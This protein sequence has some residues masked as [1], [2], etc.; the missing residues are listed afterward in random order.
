M[1]GFVKIVSSSPRLFIIIFQFIIFVICSLIFKNFVPS[2]LNYPP[3]SIDVPFQLLVNPTYYSVYY[4]IICL[5]AIVLETL[6]ASSFLK[7][8]KKLS[9][10]ELL[11]EDEIIKIRKV[12]Y[13]FPNKMLLTSTVLPILIVIAVLLITATNLILSIKIA[14]LIVLFLGVPNVIIYIA[15]NNILRLVLINTF[16]EKIFLEE[17]ANKSKM[18][19]NILF[20]LIPVIIL[21]LFF[22]LMSFIS[23]ATREFGDY[24]SQLYLNKMENYINNM[25]LTEKIFDNGDDVYNYIIKIYPNEKWFVSYNNTYSSNSPLSNFFKKYLEYYGDDSERIYDDFGT[26]NE[27]VIKHMNI[28]GDIFTIR[29]YV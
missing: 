18:F 26:D 4:I 21:S 27:A 25:N 13:S 20:Q 17:K 10:K 3:N 28:N 24:Q 8:L 22:M 6:I 14:A 15:A 29:N 23:T 5:S 7:P 19:S 2:L 12:C 1:K 9:K 11:S 16:S